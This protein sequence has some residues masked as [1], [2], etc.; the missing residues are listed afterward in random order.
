[1]KWFLSFFPSPERLYPTVFITVSD[2]RF[3]ITCNY[4]NV[5]DKI[6]CLTKNMITYYNVDLLKSAV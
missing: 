5:I 3:H 6:T 1:M 4:V 2:K